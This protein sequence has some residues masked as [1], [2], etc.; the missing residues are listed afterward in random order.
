[1]A[2]SANYNPTGSAPSMFEP[3]HGSAPD[4]AGTGWA[5]PAAAT[6]S[7]AM[8]LAG[9]GERDAALALEAAAASV[10]AELPVLAGPGM[11]ADTA[12]IGRRIADRVTDVD[13]AKIGNPGASLM[14]A[15]AE[16]NGETVRMDGAL[17][18]A[19]R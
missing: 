14:S 17:R 7:A 3:V 5:N 12:E 8:C 9:L 11:G 10:L 4:I 6:L 15:L 2:A 18:M 13:P 16:L 19:A 1:V